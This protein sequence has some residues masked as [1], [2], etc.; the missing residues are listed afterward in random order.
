L[1]KKREAGRYVS[2]GDEA[3]VA[4]FRLG[5]AP[6]PRYCRAYTRK[7]VA[8]AL[9]GIVTKFTEEAMKGSVAHAKALMMIS[10]LDKGDVVPRATRRP[11]KSFARLLLD[12]LEKD[13]AQQEA[14][15]TPG[16]AQQ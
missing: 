12:Q 6:R 3:P 16:E 13:S 15:S 8:L 5:L 10:G 2:D 7:R 11:G 9:P 1:E 14:V 4:P